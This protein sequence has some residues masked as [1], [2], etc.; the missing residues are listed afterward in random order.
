MKVSLIRNTLNEGPDVRWT[1]ESLT[2]RAGDMDIEKIVVADGTTDGSCDNLDDDV[3]VLKPDTKVGIGK[4]KDIASR[5]A[6]GDVLF[7]NDAHNRLHAGTLAEIAAYCLEHEPCVVTPTVAP[8][9][10]KHGGWA[11]KGKTKPRCERWG[12]KA[13][14]VTCE[15]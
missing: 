14:P 5:H 12:T 3:L 8:L 11:D 1:F 7:Y 9:R 15:R 13:C 6:T 10:C 2:A 4:A